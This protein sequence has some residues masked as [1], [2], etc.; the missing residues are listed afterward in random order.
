MQPPHCA[1]TPFV[2]GHI[3]SGLTSFEIIL[4]DFNDFRGLTSAVEVVAISCKDGNSRVKTNF[5]SIEK[6]KFLMSVS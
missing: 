3:S 4:L 2:L 1:R 6:T 5:I